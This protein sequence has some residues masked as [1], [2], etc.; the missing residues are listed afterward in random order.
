MFFITPVS[1]GSEKARIICLP[2][3]DKTNIPVKEIH[4]I[5]ND[6][7]DVEIGFIREQ[8]IKMVNYDPC[9]DG[10][11]LTLR[12]NFAHTDLDDTCSIQYI[13]QDLNNRP[14]WLDLSCYLGNAS[15]I[16]YE[17]LFVKTERTFFDIETD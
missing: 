12:L 9:F 11:V 14:D 16:D 13:K 7:A 3:Y 10:Y 4:I 8:V 15:M 1:I 2:T 17:S 6:D 5:C